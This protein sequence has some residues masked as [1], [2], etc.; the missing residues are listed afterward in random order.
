MLFPLPFP[1][2]SVLATRCSAKYHPIAK[3][4]ANNTCE[5]LPPPAAIVKETQPFT[6]T[7]AKSNSQS[8]VLYKMQFIALQSRGVQ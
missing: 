6:Q 7:T 8:V 5:Q 2:D 1:S 3:L 4:E